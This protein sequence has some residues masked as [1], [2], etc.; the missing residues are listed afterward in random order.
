MN[1][2][3]S[4]AAR[5]PSGATI[6]SKPED[7]FT[8]NLRFMVGQVAGQ[9][10]GQTFQMLQRTFPG[11]RNFEQL[12]AFAKLYVNSGLSPLQIRPLP[13]EVDPHRL[14]GDLALR[15]HAGMIV[16][17]RDE[18][19]VCRG[20]EAFGPFDSIRAASFSR[21][22]SAESPTNDEHGHALD[23]EQCVP[24]TVGIYPEMD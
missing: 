5:A 17:A 15:F 23:P 9:H 19:I 13:S 3:D 1:Q 11:L 6:R 20:A 18:R 21:K 12:R 8:R 24:A 4:P 14:K 7:V 22:L 10:A 2:V 16:L